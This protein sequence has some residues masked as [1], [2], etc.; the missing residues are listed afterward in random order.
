MSL[1]LL[2]FERSLLISALVLCACSSASKESE[3]ED[4]ATST[5]S[6]PKAQITA[7][8]FN[9]IIKNGELY[10]AR[11]T[12]SDD[13]DEVESL[14]VHWFIGDEEIPR[15]CHQGVH[16]DSEGLVMC[17]VSFSFDKQFIRMRVEDNDGNTAEDSVSIQLEEASAPTVTITEPTA[18]SEYRR[19]DLIT[20]TGTVSDGEDRP[21]GLTVFWESDLEGILDI[22][23][24]VD[25]D[26]NV[27]GAGTL[28]PGNHTIRLWAEDTS[29][30][31]TSAETYVYVFPSQAAPEVTIDSPES[32]STFAAGALILFEATVVDERDRPNELTIAWDSSRDGDLSSDPAT[33]DGNAQLAIDTLSVGSH[34]IRIVATDT[35]GDSASATVLIEITAEE[36][37]EDSEDS[38]GPD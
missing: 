3:G 37:S 7:P 38:G 28:E 4:T 13:D 32:D 25:S 9:E 27:R 20:F 8:A 12:A 2:M 35:D 29:G 6:A 22:G 19:T 15:E 11:G 23:N 14:I 17:D 21:E 5:G 36:D 34:A 10:V 16:P 31:E 26:G 33:S 18:N 1:G 30:R 24:T